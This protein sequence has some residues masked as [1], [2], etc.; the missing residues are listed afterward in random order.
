MKPRVSPCFVPISTAAVSSIITTPKSLK[1]TEPTGEDECVC[2][3]V[4]T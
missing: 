4:V 1:V 3:F 2:L